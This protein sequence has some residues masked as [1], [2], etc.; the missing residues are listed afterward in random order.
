MVAFL[1]VKVLELAEECFLQEVVDMDPQED[2]FFF[3]KSKPYSPV[4]GSMRDI[5]FS[6]LIEISHCT[7]RK[8]S[9][10]YAVFLS[11]DI[12]ARKFVSDIV[13]LPVIFPWRSENYGGQSR[14]F[15]S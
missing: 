4:P 8:L 2:F 6:L 14:L 12:P 13:F 3:G 5:H 10:R 7:V 1:K 11:M 9:W 15:Y